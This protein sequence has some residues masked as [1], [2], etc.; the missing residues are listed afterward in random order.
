MIALKIYI[1]LFVG[2][3]FLSRLLNENFYLET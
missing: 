3:G 1:I 2:V